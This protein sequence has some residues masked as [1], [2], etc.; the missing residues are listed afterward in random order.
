MFISPDALTR[1][2][3]DH[4]P[5]SASAR[6]VCVNTDMQT[7]LQPTLDKRAKDALEA[8]AVVPDALVEKLM[9]IFRPFFP[10][11]R[12]CRYTGTGF[13]GLSRSFIHNK[14][15]ILSVDTRA[16]RPWVVVTLNRAAAAWGY[17]ASYSPTSPI[18]DH[19][20]RVEEGTF[21]AAFVM[22]SPTAGTFT[23]RGGRSGEYSDGIEA[24][25]RHLGR[26]PPE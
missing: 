1:L 18:P 5:L 10:G 4:L 16:Q 25:L 2:V 15:T 3:S 7:L 12:S 23:V 11:D 17:Q 20:W 6:L 14:R 19:E 26:L 21:I 24:C 22:D 9:D 8:A 13:G